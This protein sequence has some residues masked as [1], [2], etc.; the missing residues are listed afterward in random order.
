MT[1]VSRAGNRITRIRFR[2]EG[3][4]PLVQYHAI[5]AE[6]PDDEAKKKWLSRKQDIRVD[7]EWVE[8]RALGDVWKERI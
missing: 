7:G 2:L 4:K 6:L 8:V 1:T 5:I 3:D